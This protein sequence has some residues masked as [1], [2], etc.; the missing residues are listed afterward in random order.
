MKSEKEVHTDS[1]LT[2]V[3]VHKKM[4]ALKGHGFFKIALSKYLFPTGIAHIDT[5]FAKFSWNANGHH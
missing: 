2:S 1:I 5:R 3:T 4:P